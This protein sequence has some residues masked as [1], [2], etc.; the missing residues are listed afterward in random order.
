MILL[1][2]AISGI[3]S[4]LAMK[5]NIEKPLFSKPRTAASTTSTLTRFFTRTFIGGGCFSS[6]EETL[7]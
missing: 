2:G 3:F 5:N 4:L 1:Q 7:W 6:L